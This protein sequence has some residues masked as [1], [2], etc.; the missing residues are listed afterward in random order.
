[1]PIV[2][3][4]VYDEGKSEFFSNVAVDSNGNLM[5]VGN[6]INYATG[7]AAGIVA[8]YSGGGELLWLQKVQPYPFTNLNGIAVDP[9]DNIVAFGV[10]STNPDMQDYGG[11]QIAEWLI[12]TFYPN[13]TLMWQ[14]YY[15][16]EGMGYHREGMYGI[17]AYDDNIIC[18]GVAGYQFR[19]IKL[20]ING[21]L[22][23]E[24]QP[25]IGAQGNGM[26]IDKN[27]DILVVGQTSLYPYSD[28][29]LVKLSQSGSELWAKVFDWGGNEKGKD[30]EVDWDGDII[31]IGG[32]PLFVLKLNSTGDTIWRKE[33]PRTGYDCCNL[34][35]WPNRYGIST[36]SGSGTSPPYYVEYD[37]G[38]NMAYEASFKGGSIS[39]DKQGRL[40]SAYLIGTWPD[41]NATLTVYDYLAKAWAG[42]VYIR[43]DGSIDP[44]DAPIITFDNVT[45]ILTGNITSTKSGIIVERH[46]MIIDGNGY[47]LQGDWSNGGVGVWLNGASNVTVRN[48][49]IK[50]FYY[51]MALD[52]SSNNT[53][54][55]NTFTDNGLFLDYSYRNSVVDNTVNGKPL[56]YLEYAE[57]YSIGDAGQVILVNCN[58]IRV[59]NLNLSSA[60]LGVQLLKTNNTIIIGNNITANNR[61][62]IS[63]QWS[64]N[65]SIIG[66]IIENNYDGIQLYQSHNN[67]IIGNNI[68]ANNYAG[69]DLSSSNNNILDGNHITNHSDYGILLGD[70]SYNSIVGNDITNNYD[71]IFGIF[72]NNSIVGNDITN[73]YNGIRLFYTSN[74]KFYH[75]NLI[76]NTQQISKVPGIPEYVYANI[77]DDGYP[78]GGNYWSDYTGLDLKK[79]SNQDQLGSDG[80]GDTPYVIDANNTDRYPLMKPWVFGPSYKFVVGNTVWATADLHVREGPGLSYAVIDTMIKGNKGLVLDGPIEADGY[81]WWKINY[82]VGVVG[83]CAE[84]WLELVPSPPQPPQSFSYWAEAAINWAEQRLGRSD[85]S[86]LC[87]RFVANAFMQE[88]GKEAGYNAI[89][90]AREFY[91]FD[92]EPG[93]WLQAPKGA[94]IFFD[95]DG[96]NEYGHVGIYLGNGSI[97][98]AYGTVKVNTVEEA[99]AKP[100]VGRYLGW[101][102]PPETWKPTKFTFN[103]T[104]EGVNYPVCV[105]TNSTVIDF[106]FDQPSATLSFTIGGESGMQGYCN[107][108]IP[109]TL[110]KGEPWTLKLNGTD[111]PYTVT[112]NTTHSFIYFTY[113][114]G[115]TYEVIIQGTWVIPEFSP[116]I[117]LPLFI[118]LT[119][120]IAVF[121]K[122]KLA[123]LQSIHFS[124]NLS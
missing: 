53:I 34:Y 36:L 3:E 80:I 49:R 52:H 62:G 40:T 73:N 61:S 18:T 14:T 92:Q 106:S 103:T 84:D 112:Q 104:W 41:V 123:K 67:S 68:T 113:I 77:W 4:A 78:S 121:M 116:I 56:V 81:I 39:A 97:I 102:Y 93:G 69:I 37:F 83:W 45:Y 16:K 89:D 88:E 29:V 65:N 108:T 6:V 26:A 111:W 38:G 94:L 32:E 54:S 9:N 25:S 59:E 86:G 96:T 23:W 70:S 100:D 21:S 10:T 24:T 1:L 107:V 57:D 95:K 120:L 122:K 30:I 109:K 58:R 119:V 79:G 55:G 22:L 124:S 20:D 99:I 98:H 43:A 71:G 63:L 2:W 90:G 117:M 47:A 60:T 105:F 72:W 33:Y 115:S 76:D 101:S 118:L 42:T 31:V 48:I 5:V 44:P 15:R 46:N 75:N 27:G 11:S 110:L 12:A 66:N 17:V 114:H 82:S 19:V 50:N 7:E 13:G 64:W 51:G 28:V 74:N 35:V 8:K 85:W 87:M 91:R